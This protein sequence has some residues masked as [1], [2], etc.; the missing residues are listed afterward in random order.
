MIEGA[1]RKHEAVFVIERSPSPFLLDDTG[2]DPGRPPN[3]DVDGAQASLP[4]IADIFFAD[5]AGVRSDFHRG[6][7][8]APIGE[9]PVVA[10][11]GAR[12]SVNMISAV[13]P[14][15]DF[16]F[17]V[18]EGT[19]TAAIFIEFMKRLLVVDGHPTHRSKRAKEFVAS[20]CGE[21]ELFYLPPYSP[22]LNP[23][24]LA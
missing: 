12:F 3:I 6:T 23:D 18:V 19:V 15:G 8:W 22:E 24:E 5:E 17:M 11:T 14:R 16:R 21:I 1:D 4:K 10:A 9:T 2:P 20:M 7:T 13:S